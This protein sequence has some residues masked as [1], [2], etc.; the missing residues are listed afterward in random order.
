MTGKFMT[1]LQWSDGVSDGGG[2]EIWKEKK[3]HEY[4]IEHKK[5]K[6]HVV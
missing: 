5:N 1:V 3:K 4:W 6:E 2:G